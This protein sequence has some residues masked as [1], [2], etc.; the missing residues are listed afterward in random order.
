MCVYIIVNTKGPLVPAAT[1]LLGDAVGSRGEGRVI[2]KEILFK[3]LTSYSLTPS[4]SV[5]Y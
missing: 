2:N 3:D 4:L 5:L 1:P